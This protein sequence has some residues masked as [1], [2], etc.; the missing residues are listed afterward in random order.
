MTKF[1][2]KMSSTFLFFLYLFSC[3]QKQP[4]ERH[5]VLYFQMFFVS[6]LLKKKIV[7]GRHLT[8]CCLAETMLSQC[9]SVF[10]FLKY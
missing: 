5:L 1:L 6:K 8:N 10:S 3:L 7:K 9:T 4:L 2:Q